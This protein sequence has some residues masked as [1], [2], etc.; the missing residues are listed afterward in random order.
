MIRLKWMCFV[1]FPLAKC[2]DHFSLRSQLDM[3]QLWLMPQLQEDIVDF[4]F[5][6]DEA[7][8]HYHLGV[9]AHLNANLPGRWIGRASHNDSPL[10]PRPPRSPDL[11]PCDFFYAVTSRIVWTYLLCHAIY[12]SCNKGSWRQSQLS[13]AKCCN[14][15]RRNLIRGLI[16]A[17]SPRVHISSTCKVGQKL[18]EILYLLICSFL[19]CLLVV[20]QSSSEIPERHMNNPVYIYIYIYIYMP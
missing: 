9:R 3:L 13:I 12:Y 5:Q 6:Q 19:S 17:A 18:G 16:S 15:C 20:A 7:P 10:F 11:N 14:A 4:I 8:P 1:P 2:T